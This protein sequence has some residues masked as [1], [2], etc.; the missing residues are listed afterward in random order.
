MKGDTAL[1]GFEKAIG[2]A[3]SYPNIGDMDIYLVLDN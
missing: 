1:L 3:L 2:V